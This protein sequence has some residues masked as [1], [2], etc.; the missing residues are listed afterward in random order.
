[1]KR[2]KILND[3]EKIIMDM[4]WQTNES[5]TSIE[6]LNRLGETEWNKLNVFRTINALMD[7]GYIKVDG[8]E[9]CNTQYA[10]KFTYAITP[11]EYAAQMIKEDGLNISSISKI[12]MALIGDNDNNDR[13]ELIKELQTI[14]DNLKKEK[15]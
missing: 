9:Q 11:E 2:K 13:N 5:L 7:K 8:F 4:L 12:A 6:L 1:M 14:I 3:R 15:Q 10:R